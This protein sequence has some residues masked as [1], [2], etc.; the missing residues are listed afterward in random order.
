MDDI[1]QIQSEEYMF[2]YHYIPEITESSFRQCRYWSFSLSYVVAL[3]L[4]RHC[5]DSRRPDKHL[6]IG[7]GDGSL[8]Y[9]LSEQLPGISFCGIDYDLKAIEWAKIFNGNSGRFFRTDIQSEN[10]GEEFKSVSLVEVIEHIPPENLQ[11]FLEGVRRTLTDDA[12]VVITV[13]HTNKPLI[14]KHYQ[15]FN[16]AT[17]AEVLNA[18]FVIQEIYGFEFNT[19]L[20]RAIKALA[21]RW[22]IFVDSR[23]LNK[24]RLKRQLARLNSA[25][26]EV[27][28]GRIFC[29]CRPRIY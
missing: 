3:T 28:V 27:G 4:I 29:V 13:P 20:E 22:G 8:I 23:L 25:A 24:L 10:I 17:L 1:Q 26:G 12:Q 6:D 15:H 9:H 21:S 7:C 18:Q 19:V 11:K 5:L 2:P 16:F 14:K